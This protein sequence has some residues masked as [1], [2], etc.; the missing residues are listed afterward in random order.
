[1]AWLPADGDK[2]VWCSWSDGDDIAGMS[3][4]ILSI[5][6]HCRFTG[7]DNTNVGVGML[8]LWWT[9]ASSALP[10]KNET[11]APYGSPLSSTSAIA[12]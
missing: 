10:R 12:P 11:P 4:K 5:H 8:M 1:V 2:A 9:Y 6:S 7:T 3:E